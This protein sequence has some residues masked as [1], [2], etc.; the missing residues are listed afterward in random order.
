MTPE[1][2]EEIRTMFAALGIGTAREQFDLVD[3][4]IGV[5]LQSVTELTSKHAFTLIPRLRSRIES[6][7]KKSTG[8]SWDDR[9]EDTWIDN[10]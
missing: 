3:V 1:Q 8:N 5:R 10:L 2:R 6:R 4:L 7:S 9:D